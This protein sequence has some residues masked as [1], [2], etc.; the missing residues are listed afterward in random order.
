MS[1]KHELSDNRNDSKDFRIVEVVMTKKDTSGNQVSLA[2]ALMVE[3]DLE[4][5]KYVHDNMDD[6][7]KNVVQMKHLEE[8]ENR[9]SI[10]ENALFFEEN[11]QP[12]FDLL[13]EKSG[14][15]LLYE[16]SSSLK[17]ALIGIAIK[18]FN[19]NIQEIRDMFG[20]S[21]NETQQLLEEFGISGT[22]GGINN[23]R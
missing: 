7:V 15:H 13:K 18:R 9:R 3:N 1:S 2:Q 17:R 11:L 14:R 10:D 4:T 19:G 6:F 23:R 8:L 16:M 20:L 22:N 21:Q 5:L 12:L